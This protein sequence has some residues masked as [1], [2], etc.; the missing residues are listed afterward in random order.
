MGERR[1]LAVLDGLRGVAILLVVLPHLALVGLLPGP[2]I[3][4]AVAI[5]LAHGV[6]IF[7]VLSGFC[8]AYPFF[9][10]LRQTGVVSFSIPHFYFNRVWR[11]VPLYYL[12]TLVSL[13]VAWRFAT[14]G[15]IVALP[16]NWWSA[17]GPLVTLD[18]NVDYINPTF[19]SVAVQLRW[20]LLFPLLL[21][22]WFLAPRLFVVLTAG[23]WVLYYGTR[24]HSLDIGVLA[25]FMLGI[26][27]ADLY[28]RNDH[29]MHWAM[30]LLPL[31]M[32]AGIVG[33]HWAVSPNPYGIDL[34]GWTMQPTTIGWQLAAFFLVIGATTTP[35]FGR[36][37]ALA[38]LRVL[39]VASF[40]IYLTHE[41]VIAVVRHLTSEHRLAPQAAGLVA[42]VASFA[43]GLGVYAAI[44]RQLMH[45][46]VRRGMRQLAVTAVEPMLR[47][48]QLPP[49]VWFQSGRYREDPHEAATQQS[50]SV[51]ESNPSKTGGPISALPVSTHAVTGAIP[52]RRAREGEP[53]PRISAARDCSV[54]GVRPRAASKIAN[55]SLSR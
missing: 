7:F 21:R 46:L 10:E 28:V 4:S 35:W 3:A 6:E 24:V 38:P 15:H 45:P 12:A 25:L 2:T 42:L 26:I 50:G 31:A 29:R 33:D 37:L 49:I 17:I 52:T 39:G 34:V 47:G 41:P 9:A 8:L 43:I 22:L 32:V 55:G 5:R 53:N 44:E 1:Y 18:R 20:Y 48:L 54:K 27:A 40:S 23:T 16:P 13:V 11:I 30:P 36:V 19:W 14:D 51:T